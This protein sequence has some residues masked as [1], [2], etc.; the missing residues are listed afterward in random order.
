MK[1]LKLEKGKKS[2]LKQQEN[3]QVM[4]Y[5]SKEKIQFA[6]G[7]NGNSLKEKWLVSRDTNPEIEIFWCC[8]FIY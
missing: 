2:S 4:H 7:V 6:T 5:T 1:G 3:L 8:Q